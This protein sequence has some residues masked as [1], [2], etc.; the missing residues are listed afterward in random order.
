MAFMCIETHGGGAWCN[1]A[2][3]QGGGDACWKAAR[4]GVR[5]S[6]GS[7]GISM[8]LVI[9]CYGQLPVARVA[10]ACGSLLRLGVN[11]EPRW[12]RTSRL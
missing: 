4:L 8:L 3:A 10:R 2:C 6:S 9:T 11:Y 7:P 1:L 12:S 5:H